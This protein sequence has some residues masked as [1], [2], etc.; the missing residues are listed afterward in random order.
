MD[1][2]WQFCGTYGVNDLNL[3]KRS[4]KVADF[5]TNQKRVYDFLLDLN[6]N[7]GLSLPHLRELEL[8]YVKSR[9]FRYPS[10]CIPAK[11]SGCSPWSRSV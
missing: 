4:S 2:L 8:L 7:V 9:F 5:R 11:I 10:R 3:T 6:S 1:T